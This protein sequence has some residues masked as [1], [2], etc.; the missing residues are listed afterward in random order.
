MGHSFTMVQRQCWRDVQNEAITS[1]LQLLRVCDSGVC[2]HPQVCTLATSFGMR[3]SHPSSNHSSMNHD[4]ACCA[5]AQASLTPDTVLVTL[6]HSNN[7]VG[8]LQPVAQVRLWVA[9]AVAAAAAAAA[10]SVMHCA[11]YD[12]R[13]VLMSEDSLEASAP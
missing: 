10:C 1:V 2:L 13:L 8:S 12:V 4:L 5:C 6:M 9:T 3:S 11:S 7:E